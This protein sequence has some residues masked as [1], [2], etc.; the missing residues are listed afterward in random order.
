MTYLTFRPYWHVPLSI[1][2][3]ELA[4]EIER[5]RTYLAKHGY[6]VVD[7]QDEV[8]AREVDDAMLSDLRSGKLELRQVP[9]EDNAL[10]LVAFMF[11]NEHQV[12]MHD[13]P[14]TSLFAKSRR[15]FSHGC[16][17]LEKPLELAKWALRDQP[18]WTE[19]RILA[20]MHGT[21]TFSVR[22]EKPI[23]VLIVYATAIVT[24]SD[25]V[26]FFD[27]IYGQDAELIAEA[28]KGYPTSGKKA[29]GKKNATTGGK[30]PHPRE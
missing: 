16:I 29:D 10:G 5:D 17:R 1:Q 22:L 18:E 27:D 9:G 15:D 8:V 23:P 11:P 12:Y 6:E 21:K 4:P 30:V 14:A 24:A 26:H 13:T 19:E 3:K 2:R 28:A 7:A 20:A 25:E